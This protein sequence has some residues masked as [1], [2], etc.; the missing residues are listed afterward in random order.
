MSL[1]RCLTLIPLLTASINCGPRPTLSPCP[2][3]PPPLA[4]D[5]PARPMDCRVAL[6]PPVGSE[7]L[8]RLR[9][10]PRCLT[11]TGSPMSSGDACWTSADASLAGAVLA[12]LLVSDE[13]VRRCL[14]LAG[15]AANP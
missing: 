13:R 3:S 6:G 10:L 4:I 1:L 11:P 9:Q 7:T 14:E 2:P 15:E 5:P 8:A 12:R